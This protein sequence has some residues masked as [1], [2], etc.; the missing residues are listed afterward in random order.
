MTSKDSTKGQEPKNLEIEAIPDNVF[1]NKAKSIT[2]H[3]MQSPTKHHAKP[4]KIKGSAQEV[5]WKKR[6]WP[7]DRTAI[8]TDHKGIQHLYLDVNNLVTYRFNLGLKVLPE[9]C[10][11][12]GKSAVDARNARDLLKRKTITTFWGV[13]SM[14]ILLMIIMAIII[15]GAFAFAFYLYSDNKAKDATIKALEKT[16]GTSVTS[17]FLLPM[18][19]NTIG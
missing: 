3:L 16:T 12:C 2:V 11:K 10:S 18:V 14:P 9:Q 5:N 8:I 17:K 7:V 15:L 13:D 4:F 19:I 1:T 6:I